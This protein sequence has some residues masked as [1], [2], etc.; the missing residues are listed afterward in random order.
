MEKKKEE[1]LNGSIFKLFIKYFIPTLI[2]SVV[3]VLYN[4]VDRFFVGKISEEALAG[5]GVAFYII[6]LLIA[7]AMLVGVGS[8]TIVSLRLGKDKDDEAE[9]ILGNAVSIFFILGLFL[10]VIL[11]LNMNTILLYSGA[12]AETLPYAKSYLEII[13]YAILPLFFSYGM[14]N[15]LNAAGTPR[16]AMFSLIVGAV[17]NIILDYVAIVILKM[18]IEGT[19]YATLIGNVFGAIIVM[20]FLFL[21][22]LPFKINLFGYKLENISLI[23]L[24]FKNMKL[25]K[26]IVK[27]IV[28]IGMSPFLL[29]VAS[30]LVGLVI[31]KIVE[32]NGGTYG[33]AIVTIINSYLPIMT[34]TVYSVSQAIQPIIGFNYGGENY[35]RVKKSLYIAILMGI[36]LSTIFW[37]I[38]MLIP[39]EMIQFFNSKGTEISVQIGVKALVIYFSL[40]VPASLGIIIPNYFQATG[41]ARYAVVLN[42]LR[43]VV[44]FLLVV[45]IF[46]KIWGLDGVW[47]AQPF[48][49]GLFFVVLLGFFYF[50]IKGLNEKIKNK[51]IEVKEGN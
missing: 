26:E 20:Y 41:R 44:I 46:S 19:A 6:M 35:K 10:Y 36:I 7:F 11:K 3:V 51:K 30:S 25:E 37:I 45:I 40:I 42:L 47:Y 39:R 5:V 50:E 23:R 38:V 14:T 12:N 2:G 9:K 33:V 32:L 24:K 27:D 43:Q 28:S 17:T 48:T 1:L 21:G 8:G 34:M 16:L 15:I 29:Q 13:L 18:G 31:N 4:I 49:D 22:K